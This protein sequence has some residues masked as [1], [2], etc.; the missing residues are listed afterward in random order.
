MIATTRV[1]NEVGMIALASAALAGLF[2]PHNN[3]VP[4]VYGWAGAAAAQQGWILQELMPGA[5]LDESLKG[6]DLECRKVVFAQVARLLK[7]LQDYQ[8]P[9]SIT[10]LGGVTFDVDGRIVNGAMSIDGLG[11]WPSCQDSFRARL[12]L[13]L[14]KADENPYI[15]GWRSNGVRRRL[16]AFME[17][18]IFAYFENLYSKGDKAIIHADLNNFLFFLVFSI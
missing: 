13:A 11:P 18:D 15:K 5:P 7:G 2:S 9:D 8:L 14:K 17:R 16:D 12:E 10:G 3:I 1:Q 4:R 6:M